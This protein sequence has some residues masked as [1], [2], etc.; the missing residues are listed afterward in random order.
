MAKKISS[1]YKILLVDD[2]PAVRRVVKKIIGANPELQVI[3][4]LGDGLDLLDF[5]SRSKTQLVVLDISMPFLDGFEATRLIKQGYPK[6]KILILSIHDYREY[7]ERALSFGAE[8]YLLKEE[9]DEELLPA[10]SLL[11]QGQTFISPRLSA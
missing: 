1:K 10:I 2:C 9:A 7:V 4:E 6:V 3:G 11:R 5:L 8:G